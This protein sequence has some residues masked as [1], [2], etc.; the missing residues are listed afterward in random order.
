MLEDIGGMH[1]EILREN[2]HQP[3]ILYLAKLSNKHKEEK[4]ISE[5]G[6]THSK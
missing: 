1:F 5:L 4:D 6:R 2:D 3:R